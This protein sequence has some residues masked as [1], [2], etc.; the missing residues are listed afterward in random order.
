MASAWFETFRVPA[1]HFAGTGTLALYA[2]GR[3]TGVVVEC[4]DGLSTVTPVYEGMYARLIP[5]LVLVLLLRALSRV[6]TQM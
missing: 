2:C 6:I 5:E 3:T 4:G 1:L